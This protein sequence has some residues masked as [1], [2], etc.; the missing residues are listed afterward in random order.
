MGELYSFLLY[1][2]FVIQ[3]LIT[4]LILSEFFIGIMLIYV[5][6]VFVLLISNIYGL[7]IEKIISE[8]IGFILL[9]SCFLILNDK[10]KLNWN[11]YQPVFFWVNK[12]ISFSLFS[13][14]AKFMV[15]MFLVIFFFLISDFLKIYKLTSFEYLI[16]LGFATLGLILLCSANDFITVFL[17]IELISLCS[18]FIASFRKFSSYSLQ[19]GIKYLIVGA[20]SSGFFLLGSSFLYAYTGSV[21]FIDIKFLLADPSKIILF[22]SPMFFF[23]PNF[24]VE[25]FYWFNYLKLF[26]KNS[27]VFYKSYKFFVEIGIIFL[28]FSIFIKLAL[29]PFHLWSLDVYEGSPSISTFFFSTF[30]KLS[31]FVFLSRLCFLFNVYYGNFW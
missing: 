15:C 24:F 27:L 21:C 2:V 17:S 13:K 30:T 22:S 11:L 20:I 7:L 3:F 26:N 29:A 12:F 6:V 18:Y 8:I 4:G 9:F 23:E 19:S 14:I 31:F 10:I 16:L 1:D 5:L 25:K 28:L